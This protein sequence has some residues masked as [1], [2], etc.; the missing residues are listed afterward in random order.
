MTNT[1]SKQDGDGTAKAISFVEHR[2]SRN[3]HHL[4]A[5]DYAGTGPAFVLLHGFPDN[6]HIYD[7]LTP[8]LVEAGRRV[9]SFDFLGFGDSDKPAGYDYSFEQQ[10]GD[11]TTVVETLDLDQVIP[12]GHDAGGIAAIDYVLAQSN[13]ACGLCLLNTFYA[14]TPALRLPEL[15]ALFTVP[16]LKALA[17]AMASDPKQMAFLLQFQQSQFKIGASQAQKDVIDT[18]LQPIIDKNFT[19]QPSA[20]PAFATLTAKLPA[21]I[22]LNSARVE[23]LEGLRLPTSIIWGEIDAF[24]ATGV[25]E[26]FAARI[27]GSVLH[28]LDA[29]HWPQLDLP[30]QVGLHLL[31]D[32]HN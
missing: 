6:L 16:G 21:Q 3:G 8:V 13:R 32:L 19:Q 31:S 11:L 26:D 2:I 27:Q 10:L 9:V 30:E 17:L 5:R 25:A 7:R 23:K 14:P 29:G 15:I 24:L 12:V 28:L 4:Y 20:G 18:L 1:G 22:P